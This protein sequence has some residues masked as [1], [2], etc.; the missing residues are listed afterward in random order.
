MPKYDRTMKRLTSVFTSDYV[1]F[2][3]GAQPVDAEPVDIEEQDKEL[4][5]LS[6]EVDFVARVRMDGQSILLLIEFQTVWAADMPQRMAGYCWRLYER[7]HEPVYPV[8]VVLKPGGVLQRAWTMRARGR[9]VASCRFEVMPLWK[10]DAESVVSQKLVGLY[11]LLP[12]MRWP[13]KK[14]Q[15]VL[16]QSQQLI[17]DQIPDREP[18]ADAYVAL[19]VLSGIAYPLELVEQILQRRALMLESPVYRKILEEGRQEGL[20]AD[21][22]AVLEVRFGQLPASLAQQVAQVTDRDRLEALHRRAVVVESLEVFVQE[23]R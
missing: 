1:Q 8:V 18:R 3:L 7:Y 21:V 20:C 19:R 12:L 6:R 4:P 9:L 11:P 10:M 15:D 22:L 17:L 2:V 23:L 13:E 16:E 14:P 5:A